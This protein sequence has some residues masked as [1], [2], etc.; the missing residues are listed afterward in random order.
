M[1]RRRF[2]WRNSCCKKI[3]IWTRKSSLFPLIFND[4]GTFSSDLHLSLV[5]HSISSFHRLSFVIQSRSIYN[6]R[7]RNCSNWN[8]DWCDWRRIEGRTI[9]RAM[10]DK[11]MHD[12]RRILLKNVEEREFSHRQMLFDQ[13]GKLLQRWNPFS[14]RF[15]RWPIENNSPVQERM[16]LLL[17][18]SLLKRENLEKRKKEREKI[19]WKRI[20]QKRKKDILFSV[21]CI[22]TKK[23]EERRRTLVTTEIHEENVSKTTLS[24]ITAFWNISVRCENEGREKEQREREKE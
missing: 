19:K 20:K 13:W 18:S 15:L 16:N 4:K 21:C 14:T 5:L 3:L 10:S 24:L 6:Y 17:L 7:Y 11:S 1:Y 9:E 8:C 2:W 23:K 22:R 12:R